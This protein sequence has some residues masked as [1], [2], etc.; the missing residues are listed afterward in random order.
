MRIIGLVTVT[1]IV[2]STVSTTVAYAGESGWMS[3]KR[4]GGYSRTLRRSSELPI[5]IECRNVSRN[6]DI[7]KVEVLVTTAPNSQNR[8]W[9]LYALEGEYRPGKIKQ[10]AGWKK[11]SGNALVSPASGKRVHCSIYH[12]TNRDSFSSRPPSLWI[13]VGAGYRSLN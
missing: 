12:H 1:A 5:K 11:V 7:L 8:D 13:K 9:T 4:L 3:V 2:V 6:K 10:T